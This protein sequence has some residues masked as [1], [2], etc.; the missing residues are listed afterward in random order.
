MC[1]GQELQNIIFGEIR[2]QLRD[3]SELLVG[4]KVGGW[5]FSGKVTVKNACIHP[6]RVSVKFW[7]LPLGVSP[8]YR[9]LFR[10]AGANHAKGASRAEGGIA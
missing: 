9:K 8:G 3:C 2:V 7:Y 5:Y 4:R 1:L 10:A 6:L